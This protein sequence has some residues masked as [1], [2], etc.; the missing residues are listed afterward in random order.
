MLFLVFELDGDRYALDSKEL[1][2]VL[3][4]VNLKPVSKAPPGIAGMF[5]YHGLPIPAVDLSEVIVG[6]TALRRLSTRMVVVNYTGTGEA[7]HALGLIA[8]RATTTVRLD[9]AQFNESGLTNGETPYLG[10]VARDAHGL[11][12][13]L[14]VSQLLPPAVRNV[15]FQ[16]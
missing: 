14:A 2:E 10:P 9:P 1:I 12:Q 16:N 11:I 3:P 5:D 4:L 7:R 6:R 13:W 15:L 8:E